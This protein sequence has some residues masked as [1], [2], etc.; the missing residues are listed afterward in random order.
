MFRWK[1]RHDVEQGAAYVVDAQE[2]D[3]LCLWGWDQAC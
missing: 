3:R 1:G 2:R